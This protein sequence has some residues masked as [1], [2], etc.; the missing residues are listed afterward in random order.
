MRI[1]L[2]LKSTQQNVV[3]PIN[4]QYPLSAAI[5]KILN[6]AEPQFAELLH[7]KGYPTQHNRRF[8]FFTFSK[9]FFKFPP[10]IKENVF[11]MKK[12]EA[13]QL[14]ISSPLDE[15]FVQNFV[16][17]IFIS[18]EFPI[19]LKNVCHTT[20]MVETVETL[21]EPDYGTEVKCSA[22][23]PISVSAKSEN[24][25]PD[26]LRALDNRLS[27]AI[28]DNLIWKYKTLNETEPKDN[29]LTFEI[30]KDYVIKRGGE[31]RVSKL[32]KIKEGDAK[33]TR[34]KAFVAPFKLTGSKDLIK[35][36]YDCGI[37]EKNSLGF[38]MFEVT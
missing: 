22:L 36:A 9:L 16:T 12:N 24:K 28:R 15:S 27:N 35:L 6:I 13:P 19:G 32:I 31:E 17:G 4:Y 26:Y 11:V 30:D 18:Q 37:G 25:Q 38:G 20:F 2:T 7:S 34:I 8:K 23:A 14:L 1:K 3:V 5:Y 21:P 33:E 10:N 29:D